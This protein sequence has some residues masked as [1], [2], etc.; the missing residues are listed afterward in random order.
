VSVAS[1]ASEKEGERCCSGD[2][3]IPIATIFMICDPSTQQL[4]AMIKRL[5]L[6]RQP[7]NYLDEQQRPCPILSHVTTLLPA[8]TPSL[9]RA[10]SFVGTAASW[11][12]SEMMVGGK[13]IAKTSSD[14]DYDSDEEKEE[15][16]SPSPPVSAID[17]PSNGRKVSLGLAPSFADESKSDK[18][19][20]TLMSALDR[21]YADLNVINSYAT[22]PFLRTLTPSEYARAIDAVDNE[23]DKSEAC[24]LISGERGGEERRRLERRTAGAKRQ[25]K[26][27]TAYSRN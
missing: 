18:T 8:L 1:E 22:E 27:H 19:F 26:Q 24:S 2:G 16:E 4:G 3:I 11:D 13:E 14:S 5:S 25:K 12:D 6:K 15:E 10:D 21:S 9:T 20:I 7:I 17:P 23:W